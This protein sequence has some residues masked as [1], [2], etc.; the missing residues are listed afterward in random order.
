MFR[1]L[2]ITALFISLMASGCVP[3][4]F[5]GGAA[6]GVVSYKYYKGALIVIYQAPFE[7]TWDASVSA[8]EDLD[9]QIYKRN[10]KMNT[11]GTIITTG[12]MNERVKV[13]VKYLSLEETEVR[14]FFGLMGD[15]AISNKIKDKISELAFNVKTAE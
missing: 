9:Y 5:I 13:S 6:I 4:A 15:E 12:S 7:K 2:I 8:L 1:K 11:S 10:R 14:I 3:V